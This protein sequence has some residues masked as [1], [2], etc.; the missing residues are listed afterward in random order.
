MKKIALLLTINVFALSMSIFAQAPGTLDLSFGSSGIVNITYTGQDVYGVDIAFQSDGSMVVC[1]TLVVIGTSEYNIWATRLDEDGIINSS[2]GNNPGYFTHSFETTHVYG[3]GIAILPDDKILI[4]GKAYDQV[5]LMRLTP[6]GQLD[7]AFG[8]GNGYIFYPELNELKEMKCFTSGSAGTIY[9]SGYEGSFASG[10]PVMV[11]VNQD[12]NYDNS[13]ASNGVLTLDDIDGAFHG[14]D[15]DV[16]LNLIYAIGESDNEAM[17]LRCNEAGQIDPTFGTSGILI[18]EE[19]GTGDQLDL[20]VCIVDQENHYVTCFGHMVDP[21]GASTSRDI[22]ALRVNSSGTM[23]MNFGVNGWSYMLVNDNDYIHDAVQQSDGKFYFGG[24]TEFY[25]SSR[26][27][28]LGRMGHYGFLDP[29]FGSSG[30]TNLDLGLSE[31]ALGLLL[32]EENGKLIAV[33][34]SFG[35]DNVTAVIARY[36]SGYIT[37]TIEYLQHNKMKVYPN[38]ASGSINVDVSTSGSSFV[39]FQLIT[40]LGVVAH[41]WNNIQVT[42][43]KQH[44]E[45]HLPDK[46]SPGIYVLVACFDKNEIRQQKIIIANE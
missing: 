28:F 31:Q 40:S 37:S 16:S 45:L 11:K 4:A 17:I 35:V 21:G 14:M 19:P 9:L 26:D 39:E 30:V 2:F 44:F 36:H 15:I 5:F 33:G 29:A 27:F 18:L 20:E 6:D 46:L 7:P 42:K 8:G 32:D 38:P 22:C 1:G 24:E 25:S 13:F 43:G 10:H 12:G 3:R 41:S 23:N 34:V